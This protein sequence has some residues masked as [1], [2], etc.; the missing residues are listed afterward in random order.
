MATAIATTMGV[1][2]Q[3]A[4][5]SKQTPGIPHPDRLQTVKQAASDRWLEILARLGGIEPELLDGRHHPCPKCGGTDRFRI[6]DAQAGALFCNQCFDRGNGDGIAALQWLCGWD[7]TTTLDALADYLGVGTNGH[8]KHA[9]GKPESV[10]T[11]DYRDESGELV[12]QVVRFEPKDFRQRRPKDGGGWEWKVK[13]LPKLVYRLP[14]LLAAGPE[15]WIFIPEGEKDVDNLCRIGLTATTN[16]MG[17]KSWKSEHAEYLI[18]RRICALR[19]NDDDGRYHAEQVARSLTGKATEIKVLELPG[20]PEKGDVSDW[21][22]AGGTAD[23]LVRMAD[24]A[25]EWTPKAAEQRQSTISGPP[26]EYDIPPVQDDTPPAEDR[27]QKKQIEYRTLTCA[28][29][30]AA[31]FDLRYVIDNIMAAEQPLLLAGPKKA[32]KTSVLV[33]LALSI[34]TAGYFLGYFKVNE[35]MRVGLMTGES[36]M[37][38][39]QETVVRIAHAAG[40][41]P[42]QVTSLVITDEIPLLNDLRHLDALRGWIKEYELGLVAIDPFYIALDDSVDAASMFAVGKVLRNVT[43]VCQESGA[44]LLLCHH[45]K[46]NVINPNDP[47]ELEDVAWAGS[48]EWARQWLMVSRREKYEPGTGEHRLWLV[49][50]GSAGHGGCWALDINE[51]TRATSGGRFW[52]VQVNGAEE[53]RQAM[54]DRQQEARDRGKEEAGQRKMDQHRSKIVQA[55]L[56]HPDGE[57]PKAIR[58]AAGLN[59]G[60]FGK[61]LASLITDGTVTQCAIT[62]GNRR[63]PYDGYKLAEETP[64]HE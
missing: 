27:P 39:L 47:P 31:K 7:F 42:G 59:G 18:G 61:A 5:S 49:S 52:D 57:T 62:K 44:N 48:Q 25:P 60:D 23:E 9:N 50:G 46:K 28:E 2:G 30:V 40:T 15:E 16:A 13:G 33:D 56:K 35:A 26:P 58:E 29:L 1:S 6:I 21:L 53:A 11:Y 20:L 51:G 45:T 12:F 17:A 4:K 55:M 37:P 19:D 32:L 22:A 64:T 3:G 34:T 14:D 54:R 63:T 43:R 24:E 10:R 8:V 38:T 36:G 41:D